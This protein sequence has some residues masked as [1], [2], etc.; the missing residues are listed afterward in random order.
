MWALFSIQIA[1]GAAP[2]AELVAVADLP[3]AP[4]SE[5]LSGACWDA[6]G[7]VVYAVSDSGE[8]PWIVKLTPGAGYTRWT[9]SEPLTVKE[10]PA[11]AWDGEGL[12]CRGAVFYA[13]TQETEGLIQSIDAKTGARLETVPIPA[14][15]KERALKNKGLESLALAPSGNALFTANEAA[16]QGDP[17]WNDNQSGTTVHILRHDLKA[18][19]DREREYRTEPLPEAGGK[20]D[21]GVTDLAPL[22][23]RQLLVLERSFQKGYGNSAR[24]FLVDF[25]EAPRTPPAALKKQLVV[26]LGALHAKGITTHPDDPQP[27]PIL[28]NY[29]ALALGPVDAQGRR[30]LFVIADDNARASQTPRV[31]TLGLR[32]P[33]APKPK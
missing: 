19:A 29:E 5:E 31:L 25:D 16:L 17:G 8:H 3:R 2:S 32:L 1:C 6:S 24:I 15:F 11:H 22:D 14:M 18:G 9:V 21:I 33:R 28:A 7:G 27:N 23:E 20:G 4:T 13:V 10:D 12:A 26:D 30:L